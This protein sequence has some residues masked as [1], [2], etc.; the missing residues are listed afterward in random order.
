MTN[1]R[2]AAFVV[3]T[4]LGL[5]LLEEIINGNLPRTIQ[6]IIIAILLFYAFKDGG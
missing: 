1:K 5:N 6:I 3:A 4:F 2:I